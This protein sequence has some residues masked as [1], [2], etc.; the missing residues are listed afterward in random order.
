MRKA[1]DSERILFTIPVDVAAWLRERAKYH[2]STLSAEVTMSLRARME[3]ERA[4]KDRTAAP[5]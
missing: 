5:E 3:R 2:G 1:S 4:A